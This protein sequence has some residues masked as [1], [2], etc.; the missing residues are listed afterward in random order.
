MIVIL[1]CLEVFLIFSFL[2]RQNTVSVTTHF[3]TIEFWLKLGLVDC[4]ILVCLDKAFYAENKTCDKGCQINQNSIII[5]K[6]T[7]KAILL[8]NSVFT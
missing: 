1:A 8:S 6:K 5:K 7:F 2:Q 4:E 3:V